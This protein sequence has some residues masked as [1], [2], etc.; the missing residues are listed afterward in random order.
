MKLK[1]FA[2][3]AMPEYPMQTEP[4]EDDGDWVTGD[5]AK[6]YGWDK[7]K[8]TESNVDD[9]SKEVEADRR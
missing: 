6:P 7:S 1:S 4:S 2:Q 3:F 5:G 9:M 8:D